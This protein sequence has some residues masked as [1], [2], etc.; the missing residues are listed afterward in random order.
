VT[1]RDLLEL[2]AELFGWF[3]IL[4]ALGCFLTVAVLRVSRGK[5]E[6][7]EA[8]VVDHQDGSQLRWMTTEGVLHTR[9]L[10]AHERASIADPDELHIYYSRRAPENVRF[11]IVG[12][13]EKVLRALG[14]SFLGLGIVGFGV[15]LVSLFVPR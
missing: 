7:T 14:F 11:E 9:G 5:W 8:V 13:G 6:E 10:D 15:S 3:G 4:A 1:F 2:L 12:H